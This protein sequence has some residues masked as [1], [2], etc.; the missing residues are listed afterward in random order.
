MPMLIVNAVNTSKLH[1]LRNACLQ[2]FLSM[3]QFTLHPPQ[4]AAEAAFIMQVE[5]NLQGML[6]H[7]PQLG[8]AGQSFSTGAKAAVSKLSETKQIH[9]GDHS[10]SKLVH[11]GSYRL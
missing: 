3:G 7:L 2:L 6:S 8:Q 9:G 5:G 11:G 1:Y 10:Q 4:L